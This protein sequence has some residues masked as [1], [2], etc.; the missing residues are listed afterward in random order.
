[1][2]WVIWIEGL[3][4]SGKTTLARKV[5]GALAVDGVGV[6]VLDYADVAETIGVP[7]S[8]APMEIDAV[9]R[10]LVASAVALA[11]AGHPVIVAA[12]TSRRAW[13]SLARRHIARF[14]EVELLCEPELAAAR[15]RAA[16]W[17]LTPEWRA[18]RHSG[19]PEMVLDYEAALS[20]ELT[21]RTDSIDAATA[22]REI[23]R[24]ARRLEAA[25]S[26]TRT[27]RTPCASGI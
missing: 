21:L 27:R 1:M 4:G 3:P 18:G 23:T 10:A 26:L 20:A 15:E 22:A 2:S 12:T 19:T 24:L 7:V 14:A 13:R 17:R 5:A 9:Y 16:R 11:A 6:E 25:A 8:P